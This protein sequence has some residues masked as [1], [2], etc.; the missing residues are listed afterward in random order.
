MTCEKVLDALARLMRDLRPLAEVHDEL[1]RRVR[2]PD[3]LGE[4]RAQRLTSTG[5][6]RNEE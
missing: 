6:F 5:W 3:R 2:V 1:G 4:V